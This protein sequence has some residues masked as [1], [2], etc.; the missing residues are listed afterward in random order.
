MNEE[1]E[2]QV[3]QQRVDLVMKQIDKQIDETKKALAD[4]HKETRAVEKN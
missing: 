2:R 4:A 1:Q 3:E